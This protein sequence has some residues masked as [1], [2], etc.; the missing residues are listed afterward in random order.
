MIGD[1]FGQL[2]LLVWLALVI[3][4]VTWVVVFRT[5]AGLRLRSVGENPLAAETAGLSVVAHALRGGDDLGRA[6]RAWAA[7]S[8][9]SASS[10]RSRRT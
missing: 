8:C 9:R 2:N 6:G 10:T 5:P 3:V 4:V 7:R 1:I